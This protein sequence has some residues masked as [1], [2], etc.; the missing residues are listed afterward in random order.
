[1][2]YDPATEIIVKERIES[3]LQQAEHARLIRE[4]ESPRKL[5]GWWTPMTVFFRD[6]LLPFPATFKQR[7][8]CLVNPSAPGC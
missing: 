8:V 5:E 1:M 4:A 6:L 7:V 3:K 2:A